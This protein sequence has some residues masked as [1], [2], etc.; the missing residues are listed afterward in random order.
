MLG[1]VPDAHRKLL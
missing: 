1:K